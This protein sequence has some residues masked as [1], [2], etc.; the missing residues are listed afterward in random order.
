MLLATTKP[1]DVD[2]F[3]RICSTKGAEKRRQ[4]GCKGAQIY[5]DPTAD[6]V[7]V[8]FDWDERGWQ[9]VV[10]APEVPA[11]MQEARH[12]GRRRVAAL[13]GHLDA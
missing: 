1:E 11:I 13:G 8:L 7:S 10:W 5:R 4:Y 12:R 6:Q 2:R 9:S 3:M